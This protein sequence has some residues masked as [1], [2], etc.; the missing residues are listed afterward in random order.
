[1]IEEKIYFDIRKNGHQIVVKK[2][3]GRK[4]LNVDNVECD[5][6]YTFNNL[7]ANLSDGTE[8]YV[9]QE[10]MDLSLFVNDYQVEHMKLRALD[11]L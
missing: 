7:K 3:K 10:Q 6:S 11:F 9:K 5:F 2:R 4:L 8:I 1:M